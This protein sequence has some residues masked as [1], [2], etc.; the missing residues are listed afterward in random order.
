M[1]QVETRLGSASQAVFKRL[2]VEKKTV[3]KPVGLNTVQMLKSASTGLGLAPAHCMKVAEGLYSSGFI[4]YPRT[5]TTRYAATFDIQAALREQEDHPSWGKTVKFLLRKGNIQSPKG[6]SD[7]GD[8]PPITPM[9]AAP[10]DEFSK[11]KE[12]KLYEY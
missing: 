2:D 7:K 1:K 8:H 10:R 9:K 12:W 5:E 11:G 3:R 6:G 4:S